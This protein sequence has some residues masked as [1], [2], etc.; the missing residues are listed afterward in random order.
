MFDFKPSSDDPGDL[1]ESSDDLGANLIPDA[2]DGSD[3]DDDLEIL[4]FVVP[5]DGGGDVAK[6][7]R[8]PSISTE[9][10]LPVK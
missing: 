3:V 6:T 10:V 9:P 5:V 2:E 7:S 8:N 1:V 4:N